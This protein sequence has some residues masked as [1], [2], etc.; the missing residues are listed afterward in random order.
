MISLREWLEC[1]REGRDNLKKKNPLASDNAVLFNPEKHVYT[2]QKKIVCGARE[3]VAEVLQEWS[4]AREAGTTMHAYIESVY[5]DIRVPQ[6]PW[7]LG[8]EFVQ[9][10][11]FKKYMSE[12]KGWIPF[13]TELILYSERYMVAGSCDIVF[14]EAK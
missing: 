9:F 2:L 7:E 6:E 4:D 5:N 8:R 3:Q 12:K 10:E 13:R 14:L 11:V 1:N